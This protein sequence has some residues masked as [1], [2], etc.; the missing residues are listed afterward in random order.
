MAVNAVD[1]GREKDDDMGGSLGV[2]A[3]AR[4]RWSEEILG[5]EWESKPAPGLC[6]ACRYCDRRPLAMESGGAELGAL[7]FL[8]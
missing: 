7:G 2:S 1:S 4:C 3:A 5:C 6:G 8:S